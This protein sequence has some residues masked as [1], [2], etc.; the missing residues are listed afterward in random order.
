M[1]MAILSPKSYLF[2]SPDS[3]IGQLH[4]IDGVEM[5]HKEL[6]PPPRYSR[7]SLWQSGDPW[8]QP[9]RSS[10]LTMIF[11]ASS[12]RALCYFRCSCMCCHCLTMYLD[13]LAVSH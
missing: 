9:R 8:L 13:L 7:T 5:V 3:R 10:V 11:M 4:N 1:E 12:L 6:C 2:R